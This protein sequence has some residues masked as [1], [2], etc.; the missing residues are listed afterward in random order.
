MA[1]RNGI[2]PIE[3]PVNVLKASDPSRVARK[4]GALWEDEGGG[5]GRIVVPVLGDELSVRFPE[6]DVDMPP[7]LDSFVLKVLTLIYLSNT[8][9]AKPAG[10]WVAYRDVPGGR[11]YEPVLSRSVEAPL[12]ARFSDDERGFL[13]AAEE[14]GGT[15]Q[16]F[17][18]AASSLALFPNVLLCFI[19]WKSDEEFPARAGVL[20]DSNCHHH[21]SAFD[22]RMGAQE[23][24]GRM[25]KGVGKKAPGH[26]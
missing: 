24:S 20:F 25:I 17:G 3:Q 12:A 15:E 13:K 8:N 23:I 10:E 19:L 22:L 21:L 16:Q 5:A 14:L 7:H 2:S 6:I 26:S 1:G 11:F 9:G 4:A 18:D